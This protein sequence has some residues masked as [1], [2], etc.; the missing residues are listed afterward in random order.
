MFSG[1]SSA[2]REVGTNARV[3]A[4]GGWIEG[5]SP[6]T[7][8]PRVA[9]TVVPSPSHVDPTHPEHPRRLEGLAQAAVEAFGDSLLVVPAVAADEGAN[10]AVHPPAPLDF[11]PP[12]GHQR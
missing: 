2:R 12:G 11:L 9:F 6:I 5:G 4:R 3:G 8:K 10:L 1:G 7:S